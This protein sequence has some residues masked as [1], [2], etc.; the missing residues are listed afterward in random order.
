MIHTLLSTKIKL[1]IIHH[2]L[3]K[4]TSD[5]DLQTETVKL[6]KCKAS[7]QNKALSNQARA[8]QIDCKIKKLS[9]NKKV[10]KKYKFV[11]NKK[12]KHKYS[13]T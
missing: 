4:S 3:K 7:Q 13:I 5:Q 11:T 1:Y 8:S 2:T 6:I 9:T 10:T 12:V